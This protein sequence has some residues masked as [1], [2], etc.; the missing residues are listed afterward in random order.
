MP[1]SD[2]PVSLSLEVFAGAVA[3]LESDPR[4]SGIDK[5]PLAGPWIITATGLVGDAQADLK[6]HGGPEKAI[7][8]YPREHYAA[9]QAEIGPH[10]L[11]AQG[12]AFGENL[13]TFGCTEASI[14]I[15][16]TLRFGS[17]VLQVSQ[18]R[19]PCWKL[20]ARFGRTDMAFAV[21]KTGRAGWYYRVLEPGQAEPGDALHLV[22]RPHADWPLTRLTRLLYRDTMALD[23]LAEMAEL[24]ILAEG[25]RKLARRRIEAG[26]IE[27]WSGRLGESLGQA[28]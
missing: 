7:H 18:G 12:G 20:N 9:W 21:Q 6:V 4:L 10:P 24:P 5:R 28:I 17:A 13:S 27:D 25:W 2:L 3:P 16:D 22:D 26:R 11:L 15:G 19:Q 1:A 14:A 8:H 23:E